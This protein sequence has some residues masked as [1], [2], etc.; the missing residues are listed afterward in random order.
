[1]S[2]VSYPHPMHPYRRVSSV[3]P[4]VSSVGGI[5]EKT[6][7]SIEIPFGTVGPKHRVLHGVQIPRGNGQMFWG[8]WATQ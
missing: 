8:N 3:R 1:M 7:N 4:S 2:S 6:A 5:V